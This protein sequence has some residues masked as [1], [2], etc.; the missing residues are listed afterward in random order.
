M[1]KAAEPWRLHS[2]VTF[3]MGGAATADVP[4]P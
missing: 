3:Q 2:F 1:R 4:K